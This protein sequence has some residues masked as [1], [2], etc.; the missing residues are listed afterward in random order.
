MGRREFTSC[1]SHEG[2]MVIPAS[3]FPPRL[4]HGQ[5]RIEG[6]VDGTQSS[7]QRRGAPFLYCSVRGT[8][9]CWRSQFG[10]IQIQ[11]SCWFSRPRFPAAPSKGVKGPVV[12]KRRK[13]ESA[14]TSVDAKISRAF[15]WTMG[16]PVRA[17]PSLTQ[18]WNMT[19]LQAAV[20]RF[21][22]VMDWTPCSGWMPASMR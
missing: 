4:P 13:R 12:H 22:A 8:R 7:C 11:R 19:V 14:R 17:F 10:S 15:Q 21:T 20:R 1:R 5:R 9:D 6:R 3:R 16:L 18:S 2:A